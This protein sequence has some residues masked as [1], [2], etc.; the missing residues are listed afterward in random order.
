M[1]AAVVEAFD[2]PPRY[3]EFADPLAGDGEAVVQVTAAGLHQIVR[4]LAGGRHYGSSGVL[5][6]VPGVDGVGRLADGRRVYFGAARPPFG[7]FAELSITR[8]WMCVPLPEALDDATAA[9]LA[10]P[11]MSSRA[12]LMRARFVAGESVFILGATGVAGRLA[13]QVARRMGARHVTA[14]GRNPR[15]LARLGALGA[16]T[17]ISLAQDEAALLDACRAA[18]AE[19]KADVVLDYLWGRPAE[20]LLQAMARTGLSHTAPR[21]RYVQIGNMAGATIE[22]AAAALRS[23]GLELLGSGFGSASL[24]D[25]IK[26]VGEVFAEAA[27]QPFEIAVKA[28][29]LAEIG[30]AWDATVDGSR[31]VFAP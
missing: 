31:L 25:L 23:S 7:T 5:P 6:F 22:L 9:A 15:A 21:V 16:D 12:A 19:A 27:V 3:T 29:R 13:V 30:Q 17:V 11:A 24:E 26:A 28:P 14:A 10:N 8:P 2:R 18:I 1:K 20:V 4:A